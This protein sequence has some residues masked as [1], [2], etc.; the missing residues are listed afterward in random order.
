MQED[1]DKKQEQ[2]KTQRVEGMVS[3]ESV[4]ASGPTQVSG[5]KPGQYIGGHYEVL[6]LVGKGGMS[7]VYKVRHVLINDLRAIKILL[8]QQNMEADSK[9][10]QRFQQ[11]ARLSMRLE[12]PNIV[13]TMEF[14]SP[15]DGPPFIVMDYIEGRSLE[16]EL[17]VLKKFSSER[18]V[19]IVLQIADAL[20]YIHAQNIIH[21][22]LKP[23]N[24]I[25]V[26][27]REKRGRA[28]EKVKLIDFGIARSTTE[29]TDEESGYRLFTPTGDV[30]GS[31]QHMSPEQC[32]GLPVDERSD[33]Y[34]L[35]C[36]LYELLAGFPPI[37]GKNSLD[38]VRLQASMDPRPLTKVVPQGEKIGLL[39]AIVGKCLQKEPE[40]RYQSIDELKEEL[41]KIANP[42]RVNTM[43]KLAI[44][45]GLCLA[46]GGSI[47]GYLLAPGKETALKVSGTTVTTTQL[48]SSEGDESWRALSEKGQKELDAG[49][50]DAIKTFELALNALGKH[51][52][53]RLSES[54]AR[55]DTAQ[56]LETARF[57]NYLRDT[58]ERQTPAPA[59]PEPAKNNRY[60]LAKNKLKSLSE[61]K[62]LSQNL[63]QNIL[64]SCLN[65]DDY[66]GIYLQSEL[67][68]KALELARKSSEIRP[69]QMDLLNTLQAL[70]RAQC[71]RASISGAPHAYF[72]ALKE[73]LKKMPRTD[74]AA[75]IYYLRARF[76]ELENE[77]EEAEKAYE[78]SY[79]LFTELHGDEDP[80][81]INSHVMEFVTDESL[82]KDQAKKGAR[83]LKHISV[84]R[85]REAPL[86][87]ILLL[88]ALV[89][90]KIARVNTGEAGNT[91]DYCSKAIEALERHTLRNEQALAC[92]L[93]MKR[94]ITKTLLK[95]K[96]EPSLVYRAAALHLSHG[97]LPQAADLYEDLARY[98]TSK[99]NYKY[100]MRLL[101]LS[102][103][104]EK[105]LEE[106][107][108]GRVKQRREIEAMLGELLCDKTGNP[109]YHVQRALPILQKALSDSTEITNQDH[110]DENEKE[111]RKLREYFW[112]AKIKYLL[113]LSQY[114]T[115]KAD[116]AIEL[117][118]QAREDLAKNEEYL[119][120]R[121]KQENYPALYKQDKQERAALSNNIKVLERE[122]NSLPK[123]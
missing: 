89:N 63:Y 102:L 121:G 76:Y 116:L 10:L 51:P 19:R 20:A 97:N 12:H 11:E 120:E 40:N 60:R 37:M 6:E 41:G 117:L 122:L 75:Y 93:N 21:R 123:L 56:D 55:V 47:A 72:W 8:S 87:T 86:D 53:K 61:E 107:G 64:S 88:S 98:Y 67:L 7:L 81:S 30:L 43:V 46:T 110:G 92:L 118:K 2:E 57:T 33:V 39:S 54:E 99:E 58:Q 22:D 16:K 78:D 111:D 62:K 95:E 119:E 69:E 115:N 109:Y 1:F 34:S 36:I 65:D 84:L 71:G 77:L 4:I 70:K 108:L 32:A 49:N 15:S 35:G 50:P 90:N 105:K 103:E 48:E 17:S 25:L 5:Y 112:Q 85:E 42:K 28:L 79:Q 3:A 82:S 26:A 31:P 45:A 100:R 113:A 114:E 14:C 18:A 80:R 52:A 73:R 9:G 38:T 101:Q 66:V 29:E 59:W 106:S 23:G 96:W 104:I 44:A 24:I 74:E 94:D 27:D 13:R 91:L 68:E 83:I